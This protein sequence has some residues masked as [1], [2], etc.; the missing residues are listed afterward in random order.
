[1]FFVVN[2]CSRE[3]RYTPKVTVWGHT[4]SFFT[5][6]N[7]CKGAVMTFRFQQSNIMDMLSELVIYSLFYCRCCLQYSISLYLIAKKKV[8]VTAILR[9]CLRHCRRSVF[10]S[11][12]FSY[13]LLD[14][15]NVHTSFMHFIPRRPLLSLLLTDVLLNRSSRMI[16]NSTKERNRKGYKI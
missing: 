7:M 1:M 8:N 14:L 16:H 13:T 15:T 9:S 10:P 6:K 5:R 3:S 12:S 11:F 4:W 2:G